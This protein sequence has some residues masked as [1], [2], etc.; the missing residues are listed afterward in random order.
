MATVT[1]NPNLDD[2]PSAHCDVLSDGSAWVYVKC[3]DAM[4]LH[5]P[6]ENRRCV[7]YGRELVAEL[8]TALNTLEARLDSEGKG[9][10]G[11]P[12]VES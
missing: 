7:A 6:D 10:D 12:S 5:L 2:S 8:T 9:H 11:T 3:G 1:V 4:T